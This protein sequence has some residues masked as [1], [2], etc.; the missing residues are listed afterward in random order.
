M[1][2]RAE[3]HGAKIDGFGVIAKAFTSARTGNPV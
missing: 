1:A 3:A 2:L